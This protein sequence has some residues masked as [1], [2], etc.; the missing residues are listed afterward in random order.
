[1]AVHI[2]NNCT[3]KHRSTETNKYK[4]YDEKSKR[5]TKHLKM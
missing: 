4:R 3:N 1:M 2:R 5:K